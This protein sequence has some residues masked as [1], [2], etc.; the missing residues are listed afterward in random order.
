M[1]MIKILETIFKAH[2]Y[3]QDIPGYYALSIQ[4]N[5]MFLYFLSFTQKCEK[6]YK[7]QIRCVLRGVEILLSAISA[8]G[9]CYAFVMRMFKE[10]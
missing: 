3:I 9:V 5:L 10:V 7:P 4:I 2:Q 8:Y 6:F 1:L